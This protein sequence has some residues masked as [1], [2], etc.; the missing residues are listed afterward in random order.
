LAQFL[1]ALGEYAFFAQIMDA[2]L[3]QSGE[4]AG[5]GNG[6][7]GSVQQFGQCIHASGL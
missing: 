1:E 5:S 4:I 3:I 7:L 6:G 2:H